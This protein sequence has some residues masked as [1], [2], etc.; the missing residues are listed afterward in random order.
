MVTEGIGRILSE[1]EAGGGAS[2]RELFTGRVGS[3]G[4]SLEG[5]YGSHL[6]SLPLG[7]LFT[8]VQ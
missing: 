2:L 1:A 7:R 8:E 3:L 6:Q 5:S 4:V